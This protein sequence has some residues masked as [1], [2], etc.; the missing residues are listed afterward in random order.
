MNDF[1]KT[2]KFFKEDYVMSYGM[3]L[4]DLAN[5]LSI[6]SESSDKIRMSVYQKESYSPL[7]F[8]F[9]DDEDEELEEEDEDGVKQYSVFTE[10]YI[11]VKNSLNPV[12]YTI[13]DEEKCSHMVTSTMNAAYFLDEFDR[14]IEEVRITITRD[15]IIFE[16][17]GHHQ[18]E[19]RIEIKDGQVFSRFEFF[20]NSSF[21]YKLS[22][23]KNVTKVV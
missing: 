10:C 8:A 21:I 16:D 19:T 22:S 5:F 23:L 2:F 7:K 6:M 17:V 15:M 1:F 14:D 3:N 11:K 9:Y 13:S 20:R 4:N 12:N 18:L